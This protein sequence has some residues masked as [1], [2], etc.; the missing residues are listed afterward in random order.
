MTHQVKPFIKVVHT[1]TYTRQKEEMDDDEVE[2]L[3]QAIEVHG[4]RGA[5]KKKHNGV[6][7]IKPDDAQLLK[8]LNRFRTLENKFI[9]DLIKEDQL[10]KMI[11][12]KVVAHIDNG[13]R[14]VG[15]IYV[16]KEKEMILVLYG[17]SN[18]NYSLF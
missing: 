7:N 17:F 16:N 18:Y 6:V 11:D 4:Y 9:A 14:T 3:E 13:N 10:Q 8:C 2:K 12:V 15:E 1:P 5:S